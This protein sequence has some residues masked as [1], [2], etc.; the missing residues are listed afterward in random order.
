MSFNVT[1]ISTMSP[2]QAIVYAHKAT[3][4]PS[5]IILFLVSFLIWLI[6]GIKM[7][8]NTRRFITIWAWAFFLTLIVLLF[9]IFFPL[10]TQN[11]INLFS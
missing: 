3:S 8:N 2:E 1:Q 10:V 11:L 9:L 4:V 7:V 5:L 6:V